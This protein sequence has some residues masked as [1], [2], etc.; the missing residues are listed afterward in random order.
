[1]IKGMIF[2]LFGTLVSNHRL[3][4]PVCEKMAKDGSADLKELENEFVRLYRKYF[5]DYHKAAFQPEKFYYYLLMDEMIKK[6]NLSGDIES[7]CNYMY[8]SFGKLPAYPD[9]KILKK[10]FREYTIA[11]ITNADTSFVNEAIR[12]NRIPYHVLLT[13]EMARSYKP[14]CEIFNRALHLMGL[15][16]DDVIFVG[17]SIRVD[18]MGAA[19]AGIKGVLIDR[20]RSYPDYVPRITSLEE[21]QHIDL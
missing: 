6:F 20:S 14:S 10:L 11:I 7:Y 16:R 17:D 12:N 18:M 4:G 2:D 19:G 21:L 1:M 3:F 13:S 15:E 8:S 5:K 9:A